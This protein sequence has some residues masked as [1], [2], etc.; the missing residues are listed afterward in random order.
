MTGI[1]KSFPGVRALRAASLS[2]RPGEVHVLLG[3]NGAGKSTLMKILSGQLPPDAGSMELD[4]L[5]YQP[6]SPLQ[7][8]GEGIAMIHQE[9]SVIPALTVAEN[10]LL[11]DEPTRAGLI[12]R[13]AQEARARALLSQVGSD[14]HPN[15]PA[16]R[17]S[18]AQRQVVEIAKALGPQARQLI[19][20]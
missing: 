17:L 19:M 20:D 12:D 15:T 18:V 2:V 10:L 6:A 7:A 13:A 8:Q 3:E 9:L 11:G 1:D 4:G 14:L 16:A 5:P